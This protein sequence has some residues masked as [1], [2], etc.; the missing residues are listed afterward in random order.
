VPGTLAVDMA[1]GDSMQLCMDERN[2]ALEGVLVA[3]RPLSE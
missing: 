1:L 3:L 2:E